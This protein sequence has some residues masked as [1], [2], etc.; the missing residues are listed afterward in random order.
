MERGFTD[1]LTTIEC[2]GW[3]LL[4]WIALIVCDM[5]SGLA[6]P[7]ELGLLGVGLMGESRYL[8]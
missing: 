7:L 2:V 4:I 6:R 1:V 3:R 5:A 8:F